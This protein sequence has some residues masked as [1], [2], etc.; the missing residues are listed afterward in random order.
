MFQDVLALVDKKDNGIATDVALLGV[1][2][3]LSTKCV[4]YFWWAV[5]VKYLH[6]CV[7]V[8]RGDF[9]TWRRPWQTWKL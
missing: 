1:S 5:L 2:F 4:Q 7:R 8:R 9:R 6:V 3:S